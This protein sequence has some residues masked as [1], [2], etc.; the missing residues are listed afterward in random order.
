[1]NVTENDWKLFRARIAGWQEA[2]M[3]KLNREYIELLSASGV[4]SGKFWALDERIRE[5]RKSA[6]V[7]VEM[8]R[9][10]LSTNLCR[11]LSEGV[12]GIEDLEGFNDELVEQ[13]KRR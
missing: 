1:M 3:E 2:H 10:L 9:S 7:I 4:A 8:K 5:D 11:L 13:L 6:G 12:I